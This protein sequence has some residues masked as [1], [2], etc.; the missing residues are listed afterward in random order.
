MSPIGMLANG[1]VKHWSIEIDHTPTGYCEK[2]LKACLVVQIHLHLCSMA[3]SMD[4]W[5]IEVV[6][7]CDSCC[8]P[9]YFYKTY[10]V[11]LLLE[12]SSEVPLVKKGTWYFAWPDLQAVFQR[13]K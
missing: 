8:R 5:F 12:C 1:K 11:L 3:M 7:V 4:D 6:S 2:W 9:R 13:N 10:L